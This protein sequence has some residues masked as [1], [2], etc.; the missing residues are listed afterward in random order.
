MVT[1]IIANRVYD[2]SHAIGG[3]DMMK[4]YSLAIASGNVLYLVNRLISGLAQTRAGAGIPTH[5]RKIDIG[6]SP[7]EEELLAS[8]G[9]MGEG[10]DQVYWPSGIACDSVGNVYVADEWLNR[11]A[12]FDGDGNFLRTWGVQG[13]GDGQLLGPSG[14][15]FDADDTLYVVDARNHRVQKFTT[16]GEFIGGW[17]SQGDGPGQFDTPWGLTIDREGSVYV[18]DHKNHRVQKFTPEGEYMTEFGSYGTKVG[19]L[20][21]PTDVAVDPDGDVYVCDW[22]NSRV[23]AYDESGK[24][25]TSFIRRRRAAIEVAAAV[26]GV[27]RGREARQ[28]QGSGQGDRLA[29]RP[30]H[31]RRV[32]PG[33]ELAL[34]L[35]LPA[36]PLPD[37][38]QAPGLRRAPVQPVGD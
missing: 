7:G 10:D 11:V 16:D 37:L 25:I 36:R 1:Q 26:R 4:P 3:R 31:R 21:R 28:A 14:L 30:A 35:R 15:E 17:G 6:N 18:A 13:S 8:F 33:Q 22:A 27:E 20:N 9:V 5:I 19:E 2:Y 38:R 24:P 12:V 34:H 32:P 23:N 29:A